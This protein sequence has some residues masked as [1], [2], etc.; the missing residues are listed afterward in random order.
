MDIG[1]GN[2]L[3]MFAPN[4]SDAL[5]LRYAAH[6]LGAATVYLSM[7]SNEVQRRALLKQ[8]AP[9]LLVVFPETA[10]CLDANTDMV[11]M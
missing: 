11:A 10:E 4:R 6:V 8:M 1:R 3:A 9:D 5:A 2:L 7:P